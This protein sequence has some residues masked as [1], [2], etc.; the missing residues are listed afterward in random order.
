VQIHTRADI[1]S[2]VF[3]QVYLNT[4]ISIFY[5]LRNLHNIKA[6]YFSTVNVISFADGQQNV[7]Q[8]NTR[9]FI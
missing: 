5:R 9:T 2:I 8:S 7:F 1:Q 6:W 4:C 3:A